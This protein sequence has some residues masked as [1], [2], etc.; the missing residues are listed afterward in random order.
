MV[1]QC[2]RAL[3]TLF[4][5]ILIRTC[6]ITCPRMSHSVFELKNTVF[7][8][9]NCKLM[10]IY[11]EKS[12]LNS[13]LQHLGQLFSHEIFNFS[14]FL[15][16]FGPPPPD[17]KD[18]GDKKCLFVCNFIQGSHLNHFLKHLGQLFFR[19]KFRFF[20]CSQ[21]RTCPPPMAHFSVS[22]AAH[23]VVFPLKTVGVRRA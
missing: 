4:I 21:W 1:T 6:H 12:V 16:V 7:G 23:S 14:H 18:F 13:L 11:M 10:C 2:F 20:W 19:W 3:S 8:D 17:F 22:F 5:R 9:K 15:G